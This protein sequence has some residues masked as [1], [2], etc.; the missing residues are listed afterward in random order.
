MKKPKTQ[1]QHGGAAVTSATEW[2]IKV[3]SIFNN[4]GDKPNVL[5]FGELRDDGLT[6][7]PPTDEERGAA[8]GGDQPMK[9]FVTEANKGRYE[10]IRE[11]ALHIRTKFKEI[12]GRDMLET[13]T[14]AEFIAEIQSP[15]RPADDTMLNSLNYFLACENAMLGLASRG[16]LNV[17]APVTML[18]QAAE[19][20][21]LFIWALAIN[22]SGDAEAVSMFADVEQALNSEPP[23]P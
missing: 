10:D 13:V 23:S 1:Q 12:F 2:I 15:N 11:M 21:P 8:V 22:I 14:P 3:E 20:G 6:L 4:L 17:T 7:R 18:K 9:I 5:T 16:Q 19:A